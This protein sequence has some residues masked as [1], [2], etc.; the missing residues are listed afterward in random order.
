MK[1]PK[2]TPPRSNYFKDHTNG[3]FY[4]EADARIVY[5]TD[6]EGN[7]K[8]FEKCINKSKGLYW[9][10]D[11]LALR[12][13]YFFVYG[14]DAFDKGPNDIRVG[15]TLVKLKMQYPNRVTLIIGN[16]DANKLRILSEATQLEKKPSMVPIIGAVNCTVSYQTFL[17]RLIEKE[18][19]TL[20]EKEKRLAIL[21]AHSK[22]NKLKWMLAHT[23]GSPGAFEFRREELQTITKGPVTDEEVWKSYIDSVDPKLLSI[24]PLQVRRNQLVSFSG[25]FVLQYLLL[26]QIGVQ[27]NDALFVHGGFN[28]DTFKFVPTSKTF[29]YFDRFTGDIAYSKFEEVPIKKVHD[30]LSVF[31]WLDYM[32]QFRRESLQTYIENP[33]W[34]LDEAQQ[35]W[36][37]GGDALAAYQSTP[38][39]FGRSAVVTSFLDGKGKLTDAV[40]DNS[41]FN[42]L[43]KQDHGVHLV[44]VGHKPVGVAPMLFSS[45]LHDFKNQA[46]LRFCMGDTSYSGINNDKNN[47]RG[48][49]FCSIEFSF[50]N[51]T[52][53]DVSLRGLVE[54]KLSK[55]LERVTKKINT[56]EINIENRSASELGTGFRPTLGGR[57]RGRD[58]MPYFVVAEISSEESLLQKLVAINHSGFD[59]R[60]EFHDMLRSSL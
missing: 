17:D 35:V 46:R 56:F 42:Y 37:R 4:S 11:Q 18:Q 32:E 60:I 12:D 54:L 21:K 58:G 22:V 50:Y 24:D 27:I 39:T 30:D 59:K 57:I 20:S 47:P 7:W 9:K 23:L 33:Y 45:H 29:R 13:G 5:I 44:V 31:D 10:E 15:T 36:L 41:L 1:Y 3:T 26:G 55:D 25:P 8:Y 38:A 2:G 48:E 40:T 28:R 53:E 16:R 43:Y 6:V 34:H 14:G 51:F 19:P 49:S 52:F